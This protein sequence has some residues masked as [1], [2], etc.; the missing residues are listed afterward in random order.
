MNVLT[1][2]LQPGQD[3]LTEIERA[4][5]E[6]RIR[7]GCILSAVGSLT[8]AALRLANREHP[9]RFDGPFEIV[10]ATG[11]VSIHGC[12]LHLAVSDGEGRT[13]GGHLVTGCIIYTTAEVVLAVFPRLT[14]RREPCPLSGYDGSVVETDD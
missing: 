2:R 13:L 12:H 9:T 8:H 7:A 5:R 4:V 6:N 11:T 14:Y 10:S 1:F 3:L